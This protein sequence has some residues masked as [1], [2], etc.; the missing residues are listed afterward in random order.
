MNKSKVI[1]IGG[2]ISGLSAAYCLT[3]NCVNNVTLLEARDRLG[4]RMHTLYPD[5]KPL[6]MGVQW[7]TEGCQANSLYN[8]ANK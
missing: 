2:G 8:L 7:I 1:I 4:G 6:E 5:G 3:K